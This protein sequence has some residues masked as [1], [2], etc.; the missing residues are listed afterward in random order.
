MS[1]REDETS[2]KIH[3]AH[4]EI[5]IDENQILTLNE[6]VS[7][8]SRD[9]LNDEIQSSVIDE[10]DTKYVIVDLGAQEEELI[11]RDILEMRKQLVASSSWPR[12]LGGVGPDGRALKQMVTSGTLTEDSALQAASSTSSS[13]NEDKSYQVNAADLPGAMIDTHTQMTPPVS[14]PADLPSKKSVATETDDSVDD[15]LFSEKMISREEKLLRKKLFERENELKSKTIA[16]Q[17]SDL[18]KTITEEVRN[19]FMLVLSICIQLSFFGLRS[20]WLR[21]VTRRFCQR[22]PTSAQVC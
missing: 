16:T 10:T 2:R 5:D 7:L 12:I 4:N 20:Q 19:G 13:P 21:R 15:G 17:T 8:I 18:N 6:S 1:P 11:S 22:R 3:E 14:P 9:L